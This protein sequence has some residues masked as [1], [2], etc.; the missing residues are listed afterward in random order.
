MA[1]VMIAIIL[2]AVYIFAPDIAKAVPQVDP[3]L[4]N[5]V[6]LVDQARAWLDGQLQGLAKWL[7]ATAASQKNG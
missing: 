4:S 6:A 3:Y 7:D 5:F 1:V 2:A